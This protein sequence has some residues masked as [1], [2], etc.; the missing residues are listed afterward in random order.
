MSDEHLLKKINERVYTKRFGNGTMQSKTIVTLVALLMISVMP[1]SVA[2]EETDDIPTIAT[3][4]GVHNSLVAALAHADLVTALSGSGPFTVFAPTDQAFADAGINLTD[5]D[6]QEENDTLYDIL[7]YHVLSGSVESSA[8]SDGMTAEMLNGDNVTF[9]VSDTVMVNDANVTTPDVQAS[10]GIIHVIDKVLIPPQE[11]QNI[12]T[13]ASESEV[14]TTLVAALVKAD[15]IGILQG[16]GPFTVFA[17]TDDAFAEAG[18]DLDDF[19]STDDIDFLAEVLTH[20]VISGAVMST[21]ITDGMEATSVAG[22]TLTFGVSMWGVAVDDAYVTTPNVMAS[23]GV[24]HIIDSVL[25]P[26]EDVTPESALDMFDTD[27]DDKL[28]WDEFVASWEDDVT[29]KLTDLFYGSDTDSDNKLDIQELATFIDGMPSLDGDICYNIITHMIVAGASYN[30]CNGYMYVVDYPVMGQ[31]ITGCYNMVTHQVTNES[32]SVCGGYMWAP[33][34]DIAMTAM[35][36]GIHNSLVAA[37]QHADLVS[38]LSGDGNF[39][40]FAPT[41]DAFAEFGLDLNDPSVVAGSD[42]PLASTLLYHVIP[43]KV[44]SGDLQEGDTTVTTANGEDITITVTSNGDVMIGDASVVLAD[45][46]ASNGVIHVVDMVITPP[47]A[48]PECDAVI[49]IAMSGYAFSPASTSVDVGDTVCWQWEDTE[50]AHNVREVDG[51]KSTTYVA[52]GVYS[53]PQST[54]VSFSHT[55]TENTTFYYVCEPHIGMDMFGK[56]IVGDGGDVKEEKTTDADDKEEDNTPGFLG[57]TMVLAVLGA[58][59]YG[60][61]VREEE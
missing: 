18:I 31:N 13:I 54:T 44:L 35:A 21:D 27:G 22:Y 46:P 53:G 30:Q 59:L 12:T 52:G 11:L 57:V 40:V 45:V 41:D 58:V 6:T 47:P 23:N 43:S 24:I 42:G 51:F 19:T 8:L 38:T 14:H 36:T 10:N 7:T 1:L 49:G 28:S 16:E 20:H 34:V 29:T 26:D 4:T 15:L 39:T 9:T 55:F 48:E 60:R 56:I 37:L 5:F 3:N 32:E 33:A 17:P 25:M 61:S 50:T 2:A